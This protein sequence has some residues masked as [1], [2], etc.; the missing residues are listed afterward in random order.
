MTTAVSKL[1]PSS[2]QA[3]ASVEV[4]GG[5]VGVGVEVG[6]SVEVDVA[7]GAGVSVDVRVGVIV[8]PNNC[9]GPQAERSRLNERQTA[10]I[11]KF[12]FMEPSEKWDVH[13][14]MPNEC[15]AMRRRC[16]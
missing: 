5:K 12:L 7:V 6:V 2:S 1:H 13:L 9:P 16:A 3:V 15:F 8:G 10:S 4:G 14:R 11:W